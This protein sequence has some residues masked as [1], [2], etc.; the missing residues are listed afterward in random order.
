MV[1]DEIL[2][3]KNAYEKKFAAIDGKLE[4]VLEVNRNTICNEAEGL[5]LLNKNARK[6]LGDN[7]GTK[8]MVA[9]GGVQQK[10]TSDKGP[11]TCTRN[12]TK[13]NAKASIPVDE[14]VEVM[15]FHQKII[16]SDLE[17]ANILKNI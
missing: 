10:I 12:K 4:K 17:A 9:N 11:S 7:F 3:M 16:D 5:C 15:N 13:I 8:D 6:W 2:N 14:V 1:A